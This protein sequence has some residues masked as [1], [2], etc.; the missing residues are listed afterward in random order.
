MM[1]PDDDMGF[2]AA[3]KVC[4]NG[5]KQTSAMTDNSIIFQQKSLMREQARAKRAG[6]DPALG[7]QLGQ[8]LLDHL[9]Q[10]GVLARRPVVAGYSP[11]GDEIDI[12]DLL[13]NLR[14]AG[15]AIALPETPRRG[16][17][18]LFRHWD[19]ARALAPGR[20]GTVHPEG[21]L[22]RPSL[23]LMPLLAFDRRGGRLGYGGGYYD[24]SL[25]TLPGARAIGCAY[26]QQE[27]DDVPM[28]PYD[29]RLH[30]VATEGGVI[31]CEA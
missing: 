5:I 22:L 29:A 24:R 16:V 15:C 4:P 7:K 3:G 25:A 6:Q 14:D 11:I 28:G 27:V 12:R 18:L 9:R 30:A 8:H 19:P 2:I 21:E 17:P 10:E 20:F 26:A 23:L 13:H 31:L 1:A